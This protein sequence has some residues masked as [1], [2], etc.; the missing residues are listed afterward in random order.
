MQEVESFHARWRKRNTAAL[1]AAMFMRREWFSDWFR[2]VVK[3]T[4]A[5]TLALLLISI[6]QHRQAATLLSKQEACGIIGV[7]HPSTIR[8]YVKLAE[9]LEAIRIE[10]SALDARVDWLVP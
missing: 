1:F 5:P 10:T 9:R 8:K 4:E 7:A 2:G 6:Y 3:V